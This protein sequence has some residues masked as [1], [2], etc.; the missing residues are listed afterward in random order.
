[1]LALLLAAVCLGGAQK[2]EKK[3]RQLAV[4]VVET[5]AHRNADGTIH[6]DGRVRNIGDRPI[7]GLV[8][9]F[10]FLAPEGAVISSQK[11]GTDNN[12]ALERGEEAAFEAKLSDHVRAVHYR[13]GAVDRSGR[14]LRVAKPGPYPIE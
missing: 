3:G 14:D 2:A 12:G 13:I 11:Y 5:A 9:V 1:M 8:I 7:A 10:D 6:L 4:Q